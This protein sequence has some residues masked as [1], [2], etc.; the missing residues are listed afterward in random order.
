MPFHSILDRGSPE[1]TRASVKQPLCLHD[2]NLDQLIGEVTSRRARYD[3]APFFHRPLTAVDAV[4]YRH[5]ALHDLEQKH[6]LAAVREF[7]ERMNAWRDCLARIE[8]G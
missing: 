1:Q 3:L 7:A 6:L 8:K 2:L 4:R 5:E